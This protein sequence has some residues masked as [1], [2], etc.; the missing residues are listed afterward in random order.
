MARLTVEGFGE[1][2]VPDGKRLV[3]AS[4]DGTVKLWDSTSGQEVLTL[5]GGAGPCDVSFGPDGKRL[6]SPGS[7]TTVKIWDAGPRQRR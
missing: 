6:A 3:T 7:G 1:F 4:A 2:E 5:K